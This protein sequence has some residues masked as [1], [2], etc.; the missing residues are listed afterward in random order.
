MKDNVGVLVNGPIAATVYG[1]CY[2]VRPSVR[3]TFHH[4]RITTHQ[5]RLAAPRGRA[6]GSPV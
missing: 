5:L 3:K 1:P 2:V 4:S 6:P